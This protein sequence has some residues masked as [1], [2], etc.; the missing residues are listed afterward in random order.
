MAVSMKNHWIKVHKKKNS[1][2]WTAEFSSNGSYILNP[3]KVEVENPRNLLLF[4][5]NVTGRMGLTFKDSVFSTNDQELLDFF[6]EIRRGMSSWQCCL[7]YYQSEL[8]P[9]EYFELNNLSYISIS[10]GKSIYDL[11]ASFDYK[12]IRHFYCK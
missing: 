5:G 1:Y 8:N 4:M 10:M 9:I 12:H 6:T 7:R 2:F 11:K 3:R